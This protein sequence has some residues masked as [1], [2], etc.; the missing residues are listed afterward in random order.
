MGEPLDLGDHLFERL[1]EAANR[2]THG[3]SRSGAGRKP[4]GVVTASFSLR[5]DHVA[6]LE[7][8]EI[9]TGESKSAIVRAALDAYIKR[10]R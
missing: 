5:P 2:S 8:Q 7:A 3:G 4:T 10:K 9:N 1:V 6:W